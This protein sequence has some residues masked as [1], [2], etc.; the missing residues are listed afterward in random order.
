MY[1]TH[2]LRV[3]PNPP[4]TDQDSHTSRPPSLP[5]GPEPAPSLS[6]CPFV[7][8]SDKLREVRGRAGRGGS[9]RASRWPLT[10]VDACQRWERCPPEWKG[11]RELRRKGVPGGPPG[12]KGPAFWPPRPP[13]AK[14]PTEGVHSGKFCDGQDSLLLP[15][16]LRRVPG[17]A[18]ALSPHR[19]GAGQ[20]R[21][22]PHTDAHVPGTCPGRAV[23]GDRT[24]GSPLQGPRLRPNLPR[25]P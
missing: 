15:H 25:Q 21:P 4:R 8:K 11:Q 12:R 14:N 3:D 16:T 24:M 18:L 19:T 10:R 20:T 13:C 23:H 7:C 1:A 9:R 2:P 5:G 22:R 17:S 6:P